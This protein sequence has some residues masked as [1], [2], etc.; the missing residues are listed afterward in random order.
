MIGNS[1]L[2]KVATINS[3]ML[4]QVRDRDFT[5]QAGH[6]ILG[7]TG[8]HVVYC[9]DGRSVYKCHMSS[10]ILFGKDGTSNEIYRELARKFMDTYPQLF[11]V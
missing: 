11:T 2:I 3:K 9:I 6:Q 10:Y 1:P 8:I 5:N 7:W 4:G